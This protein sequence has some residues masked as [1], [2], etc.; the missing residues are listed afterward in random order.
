MT[1]G[2]DRFEWE[3]AFMA[4]E[5]LSSTQR[6]VLFVLR[7]FAGHHGVAHPSHAGIAERSGLARTTVN[8]T[9]GN[10]EELGWVRRT[11]SQ[12][13]ATISYICTY[14]APF[15]EQIPCAA[16][17]QPCLTEEQ[18]CLRGSHPLNKEPVSED[19]RGVSERD[20]GVSE[21][22]RGCLRGS[23]E[24]TKNRPLTDQEQRKQSRATFDPPPTTTTDGPTVEDV[25][26][27]DETTDPS[28]WVETLART[29]GVDVRAGTGV[30]IFTDALQQLGGDKALAREYLRW[31]LSD[32][33][34]ESFPPRAV[35]SFCRADVA[36]W[37]QLR[38]ETTVG[39]PSTPPPTNAAAA[40]PRSPEPDPLPTPASLNASPQERTEAQNAWELARR[41]VTATGMT[42]AA[43][44]AS[45]IEGQRLA[46]GVLT[47][48]S[49]DP[50]DV[51][52]FRDKYADLIPLDQ[53]RAEHGVERVEYHIPE[54]L[55]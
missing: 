37:L 30:V 23:H 16:E 22:H 17:E 1:S 24:Q 11:E 19:H 2:F 41:A 26:A 45:L 3:R 21:D 7:T 46:A 31:K 39:R 52:M 42:T 8:R 44:G 20:R 32:L 50:F 15:A 10:L 53:L 28:A 9:L 6:V 18:G 25:L 55:R 14:P 33:A 54:E 47:V 4:D 40:E 29:V 12:N 43:R 34:G 35:R 49:A 51:L 5:R 36:K 38:R 48:G 27:A 13:K